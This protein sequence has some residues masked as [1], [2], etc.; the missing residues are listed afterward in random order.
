[1]G[2]EAPPPANA[3]AEVDGEKAV[4]RAEAPVASVRI[5]PS[6]TKVVDW[7]IRFTK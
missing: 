6:A 4:A 7:R 5:V 1:M 3:P 2:R